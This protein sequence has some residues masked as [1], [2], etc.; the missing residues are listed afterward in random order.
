MCAGTVYLTLSLKNLLAL[1][2]SLSLLAPD[3][4]RWP[5]PAYNNVLRSYFEHRRR[6]LLLLLPRDRQCTRSIISTSRGKLISYYMLKLRSN[7][8][9]TALRIVENDRDAGDEYCDF[10]VYGYGAICTRCLCRYD[11]GSDSGLLK[12]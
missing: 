7:G 1:T 12:S 11:L 5:Y 9:H 3:A 4:R 10:E 6:T 8:Q 2:N